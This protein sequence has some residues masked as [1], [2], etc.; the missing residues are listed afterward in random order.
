MVRAPG[1]LGYVKFPEQS[2]STAVYLVRQFQDRWVVALPSE[3]GGEGAV[4]VDTEHGSNEW[5]TYQKVILPTFRM[6]AP[7]RDPCRHFAFEDTEEEDEDAIALATLEARAPPRLLSGVV[8]PLRAEM[9]PN[10]EV[11]R[12]PDSAPGDG[13]RLD[14]LEVQMTRLMLL[15]EKQTS[16]VQ[17][18]AAAVQGSGHGDTGRVKSQG[19]IPSLLDQP[20]QTQFGE[21]EIAEILA[22]EGRPPTLGPTFRPTSRS[23]SL[24]RGDPEVRPTVAD[25]VAMAQLKLRESVTERIVRRGGS[26]DG[27][28]VDDSRDFRSR[29][30]GLEK[31]HQLERAMNSRPKEVYLDFERRVARELGI[32]D[33]GGQFAENPG[34]KVARYFETRV[35]LKNTSKTA[36]RFAYAVSE[37][38]RR[39]VLGEVD[40]ARAQLAL[41]A[42]AIEQYAVDHE[43]WEAGWMMA[44]MPEPNFHLFPKEHA[45][46]STECAH[47]MDPTRVRAAW[48][49][50][51]E[52][53]QMREIK[54]K[55]NAGLA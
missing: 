2:V 24:P 54:K 35:P 28:D 8:S 10:S 3:K 17:G 19:A 34:L 40:Q 33:E 13:Q 50:F 27:F 9:S 29:A 44:H 1:A 31:L 39:L 12:D 15:V 25:P 41:L 20:G 38:Y 32:R 42:G 23:K 21:S 55:N 46:S 22:T 14:A 52:V 37:V 6:K 11:R 4:E 51:K 45:A 16:E 36:I 47:C 30:D 49:H 53:G 18:L 43:K 7:V 48:K 26:D 5:I